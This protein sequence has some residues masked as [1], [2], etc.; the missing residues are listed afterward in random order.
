MIQ[1][2]M[3]AFKGLSFW[4]ILRPTQNPKFKHL[5]ETQVKNKKWSEWLTSW[6]PIKAL[7]VWWH[8][9]RNKRTQKGRFEIEIGVDG[10]E[11]KYTTTTRPPWSKTKAS[12]YKEE[13]AGL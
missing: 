2:H 8:V 5:K 4:P 6:A 12:Q 10:I 3:Q 9:K 7:Q 11:I 1:H 13:A